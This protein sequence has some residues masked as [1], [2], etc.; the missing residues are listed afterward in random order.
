MS[1]VLELLNQ[2]IS[3]ATVQQLSRQIG[4][5]PAST[6]RAVAT[7]L[8]VL[9]GGLA[10]NANQSPEN[11][12]SLA[13]ALE[14]DHDGSVL[15]GLAGLLGGGSRSS[16]DL[17]SLISMAGGLLGCSSKATDGDGILGHVLGG[18]RRAV[19]QGVAKAS[20]LDTAKVAQLLAM[21]APIVMAALGKAKRQNNLDADGLTALLNRERSTVEEQTPGMQQGGLLGLLDMDGDGDV[22]DDI[23]KVGGALAASGVLGKLFGK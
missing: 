19:E 3:D 9:L 13:N 5:D 11:A 2:Q 20:G 4:A 23:A 1:S 15:D 14:R 10:R 21:L 7:A 22:A 6:Q 8:P 12:R 18:K 17:G 16:S